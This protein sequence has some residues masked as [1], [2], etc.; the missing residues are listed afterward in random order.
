VRSKAHVIAPARLAPQHGILATQD[1]KLAQNSALQSAAA[2][3]ESAGCLLDFDLR[4]TIHSALHFECFRRD[5]L[6]DIRHDKL[7]S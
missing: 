3:R 4:S 7:Y 5:E 2:S 1:L 6:E